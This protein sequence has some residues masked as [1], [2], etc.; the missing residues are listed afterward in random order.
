MISARQI[1]PA[2]QE[3]VHRTGAL[4]A[5]TNGPDHERLAAAHVTRGENPGYRRVVRL[6]AFRFRFHVAA[7]IFLD[8]ELFDQSGL[9][10]T[11]KSHCQQ[12]QVGIDL[13]LRAW[14]LDHLAVLPFDPDDL[15]LLDL[16]IL[17]DEFLGG[18][19]PVALASFLM[20]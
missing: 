15:Y 2:H 5:F 8:G 10:R 14:H 19:G 20:R 11:E 3:F 16:A 13:G 6:L 7:R 12:H 18:Y 4:T 1:G 9:H 17:A